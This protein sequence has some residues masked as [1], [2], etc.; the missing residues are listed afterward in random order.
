MS[1][2]RVYKISYGTQANYDAL[3]VPVN[4]QKKEIYH[5]HMPQFIERKHFS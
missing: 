5:L 2:I 1:K 4:L 3:A